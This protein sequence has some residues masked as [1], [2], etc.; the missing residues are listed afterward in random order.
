[1]A[2]ELYDDAPAALPMPERK[3][4]RVAELARSIRSLLENEIGTVWVEGE[5]SNFHRHSSGHV[6][7]TLKDASAQ[8]GAAFFRRSQYPL[9]FDLRDGLQIRVLG[10]VTVYEARS[11]YQLVVRRVEPAGRGSLQEAFEKLKAKLAAE[12]LFDSARKRPLPRLPRH[13][14]VATSPGGAALRDILN[15]LGRRFPNLHVLIAPCR[16]QGAGAAEDVAAALDRL[17]AYE[18]L[19]VLIVARGGGSLEDLW[20]FNEEPVARAIARSRLPVISAIGHETD[21]TI[22]DFVA[23]LRAPTPSAAAEVVVAT[24][25]EFEELLDQ[26]ARHLVR[27]LRQ[28][29]LE[30][31]ARLTAAGQSYVFREPRNL[32][33]L[34]RRRLEEW[35][36]RARHELQSALQEVQQRLDELSLR[37]GHGLARRR[38]GLAQHMARLAAQMR[39]LGPQAV[40]DRGYSITQRTDGSVLRSAA[41]VRVGERVTTRLAAGSVESEVIEK[42]EVRHGGEGGSQGHD[43]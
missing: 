35:H 15:V 27:A 36:L 37:L 33:G 7:F 34:Y 40:L 1:M 39:A 11:Q 10:A 23:D 8:I 2:A 43:V 5:V 19:D 16:V 30:L 12:G 6:Y 17:N 29:A 42:Q 41:D 28:R 21:V 26:Y 4:W 20:A 31:R 38:E 22:A 3:V 18:G 9:G 32:A 24:K 14:G 13:I 25:A